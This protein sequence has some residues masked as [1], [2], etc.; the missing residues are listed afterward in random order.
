MVARPEKG[1][2]QTFRRAENRPTSRITYGFSRFI[3]IFLRKPK[4]LNIS[5]GLTSAKL[6]NILLDYN[7]FASSSITADKGFEFGLAPQTLSQKSGLL[8]DDILQG[9]LFS[10][11]GDKGAQAP[12]H[13]ADDEAH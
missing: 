2:I 10:P 12:Q 8:V 3:S 4:C 1:D 5:R 7:K 6:L 13:R 9:D 11:V